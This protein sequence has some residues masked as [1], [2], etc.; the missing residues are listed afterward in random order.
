M[1]RLAVIVLNWNCA[2]DTL[3]CVA[4]LQDQ[5]MPV[6]TVIVDNKSTDN[7]VRRLQQRLK[8]L[9]DVHLIKHDRNAG[10]AGGVNVGITWALD[11]GYEYIGL[12]N[13]DATAQSDWCAQLVAG[14]EHHP[15]CGIAT[16]LLLRQ[17]G[18]T[19]D[20][21][22]DLYTTWGLPGPRGRDEPADSAVDQPG[23]VFGAT[24][25]GSI[26]RAELF[27][28]VG[29]FDEDFFMYYE[30]VDL[31]FRAQLVGF[32]VR[33]I[34]TALAHHKVGASSRKVPGLAVYHTFKNLPALFVKNMPGHLYLTIGARFL[35]MYPLLFL[36]AVRHGN[37]WPALRGVVMGLVGQPAAYRKRSLVQRSRVVATSYI[38]DIIHKGPLPNQ[39]G[40]R[41][42]RRIISLGR[43]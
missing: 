2:D 41:R 31:S 13:P 5:T 43:L 37:G 18:Q 23:N 33:Y 32:T 1:K 30:D 3:A 9:D 22:G 7:S 40:L 11:Q 38:K 36:S 42:V 26:Y 24:G 20:S 12:L 14:I 6:T 39:T 4:S 15:K 34:P 19:I 25:G 10:F 29:L 35:L 27:R 16:G 17:D 28:Q 8:K 21:T